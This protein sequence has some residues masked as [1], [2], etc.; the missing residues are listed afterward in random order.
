MP[1]AQRPQHAEREVF[2]VTSPPPM[3]AATNRG[4][5]GAGV[6]RW[7]AS[8]GRSATLAKRCSDDS[9][10][11]PRAARAYVLR[12]EGC[13]STRRFYSVKQIDITLSAKQDHCVIYVFAPLPCRSVRRGGRLGELT[14]QGREL[15][16]GRRALRAERGAAADPRLCRGR[17]ELGSDEAQRSGF[18]EWLRRSSAKSCAATGVL[19]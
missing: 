6:P 10:R 12:N 5:P 11:S 8:L 1:A 3:H 7:R 15:P 17:R 16:A 18:G 14:L 9:L 19:K 4:S 13:Q 2:Q